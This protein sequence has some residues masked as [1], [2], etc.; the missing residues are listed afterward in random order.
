MKKRFSIL[1]MGLGALA[2]LSACSGAGNVKGG[3][4]GS[5][6]GNTA[7][8]D[9]IKIGVDMELSGSVSA[10]GTQE[11][12]GIQ[13]AVDEINKAGGVLGKKI[14]L[15]EKD[16]KSDTAEAAS[17][18]ANLTNSGVVAIVGPA[19]SSAV[20]AILPNITKAAVP[21][22]TPSGTDDAITVSKGKVQ[23]YIFRSCFQDSLQGV[24][25]ARYAQNQLKAQKVAILGDNSSDYATGLTKAFKGEYKGTIASEE[26]FTAGDKDFQAQ[27]TKLKDSDFD[28]LFIP[29]YYSEAGLIIKQ[30]REM[31]ITK[32]ILGADGFSDPTLIEIA[33]AQNVSNVFYTSHFSAEAPA[34][35]KVAP[36]VEAFKAKY[37]AEP[38]SFHALS[39]DA[40]YMIKQAIED[41]GEANS[42][43]ITKS[44]SKLK[45]FKGVTG[46]MTI[47]KDHNPE[48]DA[49]VIGMTDGKESSAEIVKPN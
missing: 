27:L 24:I 19:T 14:Q 42:V 4:S 29:G 9:T 18:A 41:A 10:Y 22:I 16:N 49:V 35:D 26:N 1:L 2:L 31:G 15:I 13:L 25:L 30:A 12:E 40:V 43:K 45:D 23:P 46:T 21:A 37:N 32:P 38:S 47:D 7:K 48:K 8:G 5:A 11:K 39:Y 17:V 6:E 33:G 44:L 28:A 34:T 20:K 3:G 36:F